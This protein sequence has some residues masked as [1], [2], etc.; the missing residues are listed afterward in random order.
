MLKKDILISHIDEIREMRNRKIGNSEIAEKYGVSLKTL[1]RFLSENGFVTKVKFNKEIKDRVIDEYTNQKRSIADIA[2]RYHKTAKFI[3]NFLKAWDIPIQGTTV[4]NRKY[5][6]NQ[7]FFGVIDT[8]EKAYVLGFIL[9]DG[10]VVGNNL[11]ICLQEGDK[12]LLEGIL[13]AMES[14]HPLRFRD[15]SK[16]RANGRPHQQDQWILRVK[17]KKIVNDLAKYGIV[18]NKSLKTYYPQN[19]PDELFP[20]LLRGIFD[21]DGYVCKENEYQVKIT[22]CVYLLTSLQKMLKDKLGIESR[23]RDACDNGITKNLFITKKADCKRILDYMYS[24]ATIYLE[25]KRQVY[26]NRYC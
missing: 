4:R 26:L 8:E 17:N 23:I 14:N 16:A 10:S 6:I 12:G 2:K 9:A 1:S 11:A 15:Y 3:S 24:N 25:R 21:G 7:D 5:H 20:H 22:G 19:V 18:Q 13:S